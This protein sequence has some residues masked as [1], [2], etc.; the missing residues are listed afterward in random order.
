MAQ[1]T[2]AIISRDGVSIDAVAAASGGDSFANTRGRTV[3]YVFN[4]DGS[5][6][7]V[8]FVIPGTVDGQAIVD[9]VVTVEF[10]ATDPHLIGPFGQ[11]YE[12]ANGN[13]DVTYEKVTSLTVRAIKI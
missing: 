11:E 13:I 9:R 5:D 8:T 7:D 6:T 2:V 12:D 3:F 1:L 10:G 4:T